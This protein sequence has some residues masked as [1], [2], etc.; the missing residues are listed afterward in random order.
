[1]RILV[2]LLP[3]CSGAYENLNKHAIQGMIY[4][5]LKGTEFEKYHD[6]NRFKFFTFSDI[7]PI[8]NFEIGKKKNLLISSPNEELMNVLCERFENQKVVHIKD[9]EFM[10]GAVKK[11]RVKLSNKY[12]SGSPIVLYKDSISNEYFTFQRNK[13][14]IFFLTRLKENALKKYSAYFGEQIEFEGDLFDRLKFRKE[15]CVRDFKDGREFIIIGSVWRLLEKFSIPDKYKKFY[16]FLLDCGLGEK[17]SLG[18]GFVN[19]L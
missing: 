2:E 15:V 19:P 7:F 11:F 16:A 1:M 17:N 12:I 8:G 14:L 10:I 5:Q 4:S 3:C 13:D 6:S 18:F 9:M